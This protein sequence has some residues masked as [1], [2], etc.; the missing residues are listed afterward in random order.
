MR[1]NSVGMPELIDAY[2][3]EEESFGV[4]RVSISGELATFEFSVEPT[5]YKSLKRILQSKPHVVTPGVPYRYFFMGKYSRKRFGVEPVT[6][7]VRIESGPNSK[8]FDF[9]G[10]TSLLANLIWFK[11]L[12][13]IEET[14]G[15]KRIG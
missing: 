1:D 5:G 7:G 10:P 3:R 15:L 6:F 14:S 12:K 4:V 9:E 2:K 13:T 11:D 8:T